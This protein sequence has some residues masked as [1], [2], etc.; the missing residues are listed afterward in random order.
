MAFARFAAEAA[1]RY[2]DAQIDWEI[3]NEPDASGFWPIAPDPTAYALLA[4]EA[5]R[6]IKSADPQAKVIGGAGASLPNAVMAEPVNIYGAMAANNAISCLDAISG[7]A[8]RM[9]QNY[10]SP[11]PD[12]IAADLRQ[13]STYLYNTLQVPGTK[14]FHVTEW[15]YPTS[16]I[17]PELQVAYLMRGVLTNAAQGVPLTVWYEWRN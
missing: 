15:G 16:L 8:Y 4:G 1:R 10:A 12:S 6:S 14:P 5:C 9:G 11:D 13:S 2:A 7:H 3:W 17:D